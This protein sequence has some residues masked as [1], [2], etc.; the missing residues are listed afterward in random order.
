MLWQIR[1][2]PRR[3]YLS[4]EIRSSSKASGLLSGKTP[5]AVEAVGT[6]E[7]DGRGV[8]GVDGRHNVRKLVWRLL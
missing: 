1:F 4:A 6:G 7:W 5:E 2:I 8:A 3:R